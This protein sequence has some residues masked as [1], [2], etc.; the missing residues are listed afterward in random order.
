MGFHALRFGSN[1]PDLVGTVRAPE[2]MKKIMLRG[3]PSGEEVVNRYKPVRHSKIKDLS[4]KKCSQC[5]L[6]G[7]LAT[8]HR[9]GGKCRFHTIA[10]SI[11]S[12][13]DYKQPMTP[14][15]ECVVFMKNS[16]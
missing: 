7:E 14:S 13:I 2:P 9:K 10:E 8:D 3:R 12:R 1:C 15:A 16:R 6:H 4:P 11:Q 5:S